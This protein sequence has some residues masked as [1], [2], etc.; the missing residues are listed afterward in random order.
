M[1]RTQLKITGTVQ[2]VGFRPCVYGVANL[3]DLTGF[4]RND[5]A[6][7]TIE[8]QG[9]Q[10]NNF[11]S[12][13]KESL[14]LLAVIDSVESSH[15][16]IVAGEKKFTILHSQSNAEVI[17]KISPDVGVCKDCL[18]ELF[19]AESR[20][21]QYP[22]LNCTNCG[23][24]LTITNDLPYDRAKTSMKKFIMCD[25][26][27]AAYSDPLDRR[28]HAQPIA[29][30]KCGPELS[31]S[32][33]EIANRINAGKIVAVKGIGGYQIICD[34]TN[35]ETVKKLR[36]RK[37]RDS[38]PFALMMLNTKSAKQFVNILNEENELLESWR[39]P[40]VLMKQ[41]EKMLPDAVASGLSE[42]GIM[43]PYSPI[44]YLIFHALLDHPAGHDWLNKKNNIAL[45][46][47][48]ANLSGEPLIIDDEEACLGLNEIAD[49]VVSY[50]REI[51]TRVDDSVVRLINHTP[52]FI[53]RARG[54]VP[55]GI[56][57]AKKVPPGIAV[58]GHLKNTICI[59]RGDEAFVSQYLGDMDNPESIEFFH[60]TLEHLLKI[61]NVK[62]EF[63]AHDLHP[64]FYTT[65]F[66]ES[67]GLPTFA[68]QHHHAHLLS[69]AAE[70][71][72]TESA[73]GL[74]LDGY[75]YG[76]N[77]ESWG[78]ELMLLEGGSYQ[79]LGHLKRMLQPGG[80]IA[81]R[82]P[83]RMA[84]SFLQCRCLHNQPNFNFKKSMNKIVRLIM[85]TPALEGFDGAEKLIKLLNSKIEIPQTSSCGRLFDTASSLL[86]VCHINRY[87][88]EAAMRLESLVTKPKVFK[89]GWSIEDNQLNLSPLLQHLLTC[90][91]AEGANIFY[92]TLIAASTDWIVQNAKQDNIKNILLSGGCFSNKVLAEG[93][94]KNLR[95]HNLNPFLPYKLPPNDGGISLGQAVIAGKFISH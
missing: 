7:V 95:S 49:H 23:P 5:E 94:I 20:F 86:N 65:Q 22:F 47:T 31:M 28:Y 42:L 78:G 15:T 83:W 39:R 89:N 4:V 57:L 61:L 84:V 46:A 54:F 48:S 13:L 56:K 87:E 33:T 34:A 38:K 37:L 59:T 71:H 35:E 66:A 93:L 85:Q 60:E 69:V 21:Y 26:C 30:E 55:A 32:V 25:D 44:H 81:A 2:G 50:N 29:C 80:D 14:P 45:I 41:R 72:I 19:D 77:G 92:G 76:A 63:I 79:R 90:D 68:V 73:I 52:Y 17:A 82:E 88:G 18:H 3:L 64:D 51:L 10:A 74:A 1:V 53:R 43:L 40:I 12:K 11:L 9:I 62:P 75:G 91:S 16:P 6:G 8:V 24:R 36:E 70:H 58:G 27:S 67:F